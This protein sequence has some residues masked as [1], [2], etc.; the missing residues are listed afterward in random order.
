MKFVRT[1]VVAAIAA[2]ALAGSGPVGVA[3]AQ[4]HGALRKVIP[5]DWSPFLRRTFSELPQGTTLQKLVQ[6]SDEVSAY[7]D[8]AARRVAGKMDDTALTGRSAMDEAIAAI[9][10]AKGD[11]VHG[12]IDDLVSSLTIQANQ[13][14]AARQLNGG[15]V[16]AGFK[17]I[18]GDEALLAAVMKRTEAQKAA[19]GGRMWKRTDGFYMSIAEN[20]RAAEVLNAL[21]SGSKE[22]LSTAEL[23]QLR[24]AMAAS[25]DDVT[26]YQRALR[27]ALK[28]GESRGAVKGAADDATPLADN[29]AGVDRAAARKV[30]REAMAK[31]RASY[32]R[33]DYEAVTGA[34]DM[35]VGTLENS[36]PFKNADEMY[37]AV[38]RSL[39]GEGADG[40]RVSASAEGVLDALQTKSADIAEARRLNNGRL[41][42]GVKQLTEAEQQLKKQLE[43]YFSGEPKPMKDAAGWFYSASEMKQYEEVLE[44]LRQG[45]EEIKGIFATGRYD[46]FVKNN[47]QFYDTELERSLRRAFKY[48]QDKLPDET[49]TSTVYRHSAGDGRMHGTGGYSTLI[50]YP[51]SGVSSSV[52]VKFDTQWLDDVLEASPAHR[53]LDDVRAWAALP[54]SAWKPN[55]VFA[56][57]DAQNAAR[58]DLYQSTLRALKEGKELDGRQ[59]SRVRFSLRTAS[60]MGMADMAIANAARQRDDIMLAAAKP[61]GAAPAAWPRRVATKTDAQLEKDA[62]AAAARRVELEKA[63]D[64]VKGGKTVASLAEA[65]EQATKDARTAAYRVVMTDPQGNWMNFPL[66]NPYSGA[67]Y[68]E[69]TG[70]ALKK[71]RSALKVGGRFRLSVGARTLKDALETKK[72]AAADATAV[73]MGVL[74]DNVPALTTAEQQLLDALDTFFSKNPV[75][76]G[77]FFRPLVAE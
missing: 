3:D 32:R 11:A 55:A 54:E 40:R 9:D 2:L 50:N 41:P 49:L 1:F 53:D 8:D 76:D 21:K 57:L 33:A 6:Q 30:A 42:S 36:N 58:L 31:V 14:K 34:G 4:L 67:G 68:T 28:D 71:V 72:K 64:G 59:L 26:P 19:G 23:R 29:A 77:I 73:N 52:V 62:A 15:E 60:P 5:A 27:R 75:E 61:D 63:A 10:P 69:L 43:G 7:A 18:E 13:M 46:K 48:A 38:T 66:H 74:P 51:D 45:P 20:K 39:T 22:S 47:M 16:P 25:A 65:S 17:V 70:D 12:S 44:A 56:N 24:D 37:S 35:I